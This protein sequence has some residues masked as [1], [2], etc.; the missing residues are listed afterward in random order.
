MNKNTKNTVVLS[1]IIPVYNKEG[2]LSELYRRLIYVL[3]NEL[4]ET[5]EIIFVDDGSKDNSCNI[6]I[7]DY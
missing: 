7:E 3:E 5:Y 4:H 6:I 1:I 2:N